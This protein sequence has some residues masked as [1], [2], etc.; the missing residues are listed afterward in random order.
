MTSNQP[1]IAAIIEVLAT[2]APE[3]R[4]LQLDPH[5]PLRDQLELDS[6][7]HLHFLVGLHGRFGV[8]I[9]EPDYGGM[10][11]LDELAAYIEARSRSGP[12]PGAA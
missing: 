4:D 1:L 11:K 7:D 5:A 9:P 6:M 3:V 2:V 12:S 10:R 8:D